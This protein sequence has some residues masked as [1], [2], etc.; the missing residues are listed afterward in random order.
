MQ[1]TE[2]DYFAGNLFEVKSVFFTFRAEHEQL[3]KTI[4]Q[5]IARSLMQINKR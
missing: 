4:V 2:R 1:Y 3:R 5:Q